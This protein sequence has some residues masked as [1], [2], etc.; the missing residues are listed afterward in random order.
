MYDRNWP[1]FLDCEKFPRFNGD[2]HMCIPLPENV[3]DVSLKYENKIK[4]KNDG[5]KHLNSLTSNDHFMNEV[6]ETKDKMADGKIEVCFYL[7]LY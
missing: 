3:I 4:I 1:S 7:I 5:Y 2:G 6:K